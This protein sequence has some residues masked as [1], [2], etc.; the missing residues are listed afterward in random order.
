[1][2]V[3]GHFK[4]IVNCEE[5]LEKKN[6]KPDTKTANLYTV[7]VEPLLTDTSIIPTLL[8]YGQFSWS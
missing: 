1:M 5:W 4:R 6:L 3:S 8:Y 2:E 7:T